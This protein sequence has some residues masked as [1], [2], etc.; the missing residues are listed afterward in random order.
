MPWIAFARRRPLAPPW[1]AWG[2]ATRS[3]PAT[4]DGPAEAAVRSDERGHVL[5]AVT[6]LPLPSATALLLAF[7][8]GLSAAE[9]AAAADMPLGTAKSRLRLG[10]EKARERLDTAA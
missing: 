3:G 9:I 4:D 2:C 5:A 1:N 7:G 10:L 8:R 6:E